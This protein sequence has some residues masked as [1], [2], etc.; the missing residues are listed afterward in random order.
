MHSTIVQFASGNI[1][2]IFKLQNIN[3]PRVVMWLILFSDIFRYFSTD[4]EFIF[5]CRYVVK[6]LKLK[7]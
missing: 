7:R 4:Q 5:L 2:R 3:F 1:R 6:L